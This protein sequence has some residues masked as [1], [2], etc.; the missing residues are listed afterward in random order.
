MKECFFGINELFWSGN[1]LFRSGEQLFRS[2][3]EIFR[4]I[5]GLFFGMKEYFFGINELFRSGEQLFRS[6]N[7]IFRGINGL[8]LGM[9]ECFFGINELFRSGE[10][11]FRSRNEIFRG[12]NELLREINHEWEVLMMNWKISV[13]SNIPDI[14]A[15]RILSLTCFQVLSHSLFFQKTLSEYWHYCKTCCYG[16]RLYLTH[17]II[18]NRSAEFDS[19]DLFILDNYSG[20]LRASKKLEISFASLSEIL[21]LSS[22]SGISFSQRVRVYC[23]CG[24]MLWQIPQWLTYKL[25]PSIKLSVGTPVRLESSID[26][27]YNAGL[28]AQNSTAAEMIIL[29]LILEFIRKN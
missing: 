27:M 17:F 26:G 4:G 1:Y 7:E 11:L 18:I 23:S 29:F 9:K 20:L 25:R 12:I 8:F 24:C 3:N 6:R 28:H 14:A 13:R 10:Q 5:N 19:T 22:M 15:S 16:L 21:A 2:R